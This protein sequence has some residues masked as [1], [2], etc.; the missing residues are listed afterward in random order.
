M[1]NRFGTFQH[2]DLAW[3][4]TSLGRGDRKFANAIARRE[5]AGG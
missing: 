1:Q 3:Q 4:R 2:W 5:A